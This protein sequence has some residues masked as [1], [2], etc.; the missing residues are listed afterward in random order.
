VHQIHKKKPAKS[1]VT[2][3]H[4]QT[5]LNNKNFNQLCEYKTKSVEKADLNNK[6]F[7]QL[8]EQQ[9]DINKNMNKIYEKIADPN[10]DLLGKKVT[11]FLLLEDV[12]VR[13]SLSCHD[14]DF[15][16]ADD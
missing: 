7:N 8:H 4:K 3:I 10:E 9:C 6:N 12:R 15:D 13:V 1:I 11:F 14:H 5:G 16:L 2:K